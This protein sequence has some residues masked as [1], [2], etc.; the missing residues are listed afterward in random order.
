MVGAIR[1]NFIASLCMSALI[2]MTINARNDEELFLRG[3]KHYQHKDYDNALASYEL[4]DK[5]GRAVFY[6][7]GNCYFHK[8]DYAQ[9]LVYWSRA[10]RGATAQE[11]DQIKRNKEHVLQIVGIQ[12]EQS[13]WS[14]VLHMFHTTLPYVSLIILQIF[15]LLC[16]YLFIFYARRE[17]LSSKKAILSCFSFFIIISGLFLEL[18]YT[19][20]NISTGIVIKKEAQLFVG[21]DKGLQALSPVLYAYDVTIKEKREGWYK[22]QYADMIGWV[23]ADVV[24]II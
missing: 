15:F 9:A 11:Y 18:H 22:I 7:M 20:Q 3:N 16:W 17:N 6:N 24:Q 2:T 1:K 4:I 21:P 8:D 10:E 13:W 19:R 14:I 5:K 23:Q 12:K